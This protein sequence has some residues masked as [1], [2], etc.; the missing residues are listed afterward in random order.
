VLGVGRQTSRPGSWRSIRSTSALVHLFGG[1][2]VDA[3]LSRWVDVDPDV[4]TA[5]M[6]GLA[7][8]F[9]DAARRPA[10]L[11]L[12]TVRQFQADQG[13]ATL[14]WVRRRVR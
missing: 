2:D 9:T 11:G 4:A 3:L 5:V 14:A 7:G 13:T 1:H 8:Y 10:P 12:P 6:A